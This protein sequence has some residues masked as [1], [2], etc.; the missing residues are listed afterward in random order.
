VGL[1]STFKKSAQTVFRAFGDVP[2]ICSYT[3]YGETSYDAATDTDT[4]PTTVYPDLKM[5]LSS[6]SLSDR[7]RNKTIQPKDVKA[8]IAVDDLNV[9]PS[10]DHLVTVTSSSDVTFRS[11]DTFN[12]IAYTNDPAE[13]LFIIHLRAVT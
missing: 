9:E 8:L 12:V 13:A 3:I 7:Q 4:T 2:I 1:Q 11:G 10:T 5:F 6:F